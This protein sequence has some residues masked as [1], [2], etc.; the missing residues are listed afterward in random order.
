[1][2]AIREHNTNKLIISK[3][4]HKSVFQSKFE[5]FDSNLHIKYYEIYKDINV[6]CGRSCGIFPLFNIKY[7]F[8]YSTVP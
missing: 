5:T 2:D 6:I 3:V 8:K 7:F 1:V 4:S